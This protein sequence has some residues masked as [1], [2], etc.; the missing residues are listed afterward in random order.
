MSLAFRIA[1]D[2]QPKV[3]SRVPGFAEEEIPF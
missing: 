2:Q 1:D 3:N